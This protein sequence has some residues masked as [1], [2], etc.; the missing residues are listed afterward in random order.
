VEAARAVKRARR[1]LQVEPDRQWGKELLRLLEE[2]QLA[3]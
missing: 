2:I 1:A 3:K